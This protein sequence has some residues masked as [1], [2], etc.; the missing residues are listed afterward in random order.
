MDLGLSGKKAVITGST[1]GIGRAI[2]ERLLDEGASVAI[3]ARNADEVTKAVEELSA[4]GAGQVWGQP[5]DVG[6][7]DAFKAW[8]EAA[9]GALGGCDIF[10]SNTSAGGGGA[11][12]EKFKKLFEV[13]LL[14]LVRGVEVL[15]DALKASDG[16]AV[17]A[18]ATTTAIEA[19]PGS[20]AYG[21][22]KAALIAAVA[23]MANTLGAD[24]VRAN[25]VS[26]GPIFI[27][28]GAWNRIKDGMEGFYNATVKSHPSG[29]LGS[30]EEVANVVAFLA[31]P[32]ASWVTGE[33][34][35]VDGG[36]TKRVAF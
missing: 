20:G 17:V 36:F 11:D 7:G 24:G 34:I 22:M 10:V 6:D 23:D 28:G 32:A 9:A 21:T 16:G 18:I 33:N 13:D 4:R 26:P 35:V 5:V 29:R 2:A 14:G 1:K 3:G 15:G 8:C 30:A 27:E 12:E 31:S 25:T 19:G